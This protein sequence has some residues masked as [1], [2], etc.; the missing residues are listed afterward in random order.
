MNDAEKSVCRSVKNIFDKAPTL[1]LD[2]D[3]TIDEAV[4]F[5]SILSNVWPGRVV[6]I[7]YRKDRQ[8]A[9]DYLKDL[10]VYY[11]DLVLSG[12]LDKSKAVRENGVDVFIDDQDECLKSIDPNVAVMKFRNSGNSS[13]GKWLYSDSTGAKV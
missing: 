4:D 13:N 5:F 1:G 7:T 11:D 9:I 6:V 12:S 3:G 10:G 2:I 8:K